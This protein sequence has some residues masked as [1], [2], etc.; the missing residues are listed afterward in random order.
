MSISRSAARA[1][2]KALIE[3]C[4]AEPLDSA[5]RRLTDFKAGRLHARDL[6]KAV[7]WADRVPVG[8][9]LYATDGSNRFYW[10]RRRMTHFLPG[11]NCL[12]RLATTYYGDSAATIYIRHDG[13]VT[14]RRPSGWISAATLAAARYGG[15][16]GTIRQWGWRDNEDTDLRVDV[17]QRMRDQDD[18]RLYRDIRSTYGRHLE[19]QMAGAR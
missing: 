7:L 17:A 12:G 1:A 5:D 13:Q 2:Y 19:N 16:D 14:D 10:V 6:R 3:A 4:P 8:A 11:W 9:K 18:A 15:L